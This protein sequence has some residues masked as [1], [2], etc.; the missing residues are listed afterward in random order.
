MD[1]DVAGYPSSGFYD[2]YVDDL[3]AYG[4]QEFLRHFS[5]LFAQACKVAGD[6]ARDE[7]KAAI[8][9]KYESLGWLFGENAAVVFPNTKGLLNLINLFFTTVPWDI[10]RKDKVSVIL[11]MRLGSYAS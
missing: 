10:R 4:I 3:Y 2:M 1:R 6:N 9:A 5:S 8:M 7:S 11:L